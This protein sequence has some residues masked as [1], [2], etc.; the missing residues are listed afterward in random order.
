MMHTL[1]RRNSG[2]V[3]YLK[4]VWT[5]LVPGAGT[6]TGQTNSLVTR[7]YVTNPVHG[8]VQTDKYDL[9]REHKA[10]RTRNVGINARGGKGIELVNKEE[11]V[12]RSS[13]NIREGDGRNG[14]C[15]EGDRAADG[16]PQIKI[17]EGKVAG[18]SSK[19]VG[20]D[21]GSAVRIAEN[22]LV[23][24]KDLIILARIN[25]LN[26]S[27]SNVDGRTRGRGEEV[28]SC[29]GRKLA[30]SIDEKN[31]KGNGVRTKPRT[32]SSEGDSLERESKA[33]E[34]ILHR[35]T[36]RL[37]FE[38]TSTTGNRIQENRRSES[39]RGVS[40]SNRGINGNRDGRIIDMSFDT[41]GKIVRDF[42]TGNRA[43]VLGRDK[44][45]TGATEGGTSIITTVRKNAAA[46][47]V[48]HK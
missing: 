24:V 35:S 2:S 38:D 14:G 43:R 44:A 34:N 19:L 40:R 20:G 15:S 13:C 46:T 26:T 18:R 33:K 23:V 29:N 16:D 11:E 37:A 1:R 25:P 47:E 28:S 27:S 48:S 36:L 8:D 21:S 41:R 39:G 10:S 22:E 4:S 9:R 32:S 45:R 12:K 7:R 6:Q 42:A 5:W 31:A 17:L 3:P 30:R